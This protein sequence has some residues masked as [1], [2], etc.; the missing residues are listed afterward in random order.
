MN[1]VLGYLRII[2]NSFYANIIDHGLSG[3]SRYYFYTFGFY[4]IHS[5]ITY[6]LQLQLYIGSIDIV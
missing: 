4:L 6:H 2:W 5:Q 1:E 3:K